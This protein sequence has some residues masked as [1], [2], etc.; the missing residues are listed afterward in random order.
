MIW[1]YN[2]LSILGHTIHQI[3]FYWIN[4]RKIPQYQFFLWNLD[5][6]SCYLIHHRG[7]ARTNQQGMFAV[8]ARSSHA[9]PAV[10]AN[11]IDG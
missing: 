6:M 3:M 8:P 5:S 4:T 2:L 9:P 1:G 7:V 11:L 10:W